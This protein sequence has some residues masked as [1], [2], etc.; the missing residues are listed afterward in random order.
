MTFR[1]V[2]ITLALA[3]VIWLVAMHMRTNPARNSETVQGFRNPKG[4]DAF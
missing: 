2:G 1:A 4:F 3:L